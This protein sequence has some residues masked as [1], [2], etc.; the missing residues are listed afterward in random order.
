MAFWKHQGEPSMNDNLKSLID[1]A[2]N[3]V[4]AEKG[5]LKTEQ[6]RRQEEE[7]ARDYKAFK[8]KVENVLGQDTLDA[9]DYV[10]FN[11]SYLSNSMQFQVG[12]RTFYL[13]Q[14]TGTLVQL[15]EDGRSLHWGHQFNL[16]NA[17]A[18]DSFLYI[19]GLALK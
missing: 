12:S 13:K 10:V 9:L 1:Q 11:K 8:N 7:F 15:N 14:V 16:N 6:A 2:N 3:R 17:D 4:E 5:A 18:R 19:L